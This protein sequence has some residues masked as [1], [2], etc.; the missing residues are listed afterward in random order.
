MKFSLASLIAFFIFLQ[1]PAQPRKLLLRDEG[2]SQ[3]SYIDLKDS[4][5]NWY[6]SIPNGRDMQLVGKGLVL[7]GTNNGYEERDIRDGS[8]RY[9]LTGFPGT[10]S[11]RRLR[12]GNTML[13]G[14][15]W[16]NQKGIVLVEVDKQGN[17]VRQILYPGFNYV[18]LLRET[19]AGNF[20]ITSNDTVI[21]GN[22]K[23]EIVWMAKISSQ[24]QPHA[25][26]PLRLANG[27]TLVSGGYAGNMQLFSPEGKLI[28][29]I[30]GPD[31]VKPNFYAGYQILPDGNFVV[32]NWQGHGPA[33]G[34]K[35]NQLLEYSMDGKLLWSWKQDP[36]HFSSL[37][38][39]IVLDQ[40]D[41][42]LLYIEDRDGKLSPVK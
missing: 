18:R 36:R 10:I 19:P 12:N 11:A 7:I 2:L 40:L 25:W 6:V 41:P 13:V 17:T 35:G 37:H 24:K 29:T 22:A 30:T 26:Q 14:V 9:E 33:M 31:E 23:A 21:E 1:T 42:S 38:A 8:K 3:L 20:L 28:Q 27:N 15:N 39:V 5:A 16:Q 32:I 4:S 34:E